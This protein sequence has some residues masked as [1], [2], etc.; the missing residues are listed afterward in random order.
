[1]SRRLDEILPWLPELRRQW[2]EIDA[3]HRVFA[4]HFGVRPI[5]WSRHNLTRLLNKTGEP[6][7]RILAVRDLIDHRLRMDSAIDQRYLVDCLSVWDHG[8]MWARDGQPCMMV[9]HPYHIND[10]ERALLD[11]LARW[12]PRLKLSIDD[13]ESYY[14]PKCTHHI[15]LEL[16]RF[17]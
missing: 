17:P 1:M 3:R 9:G 10:E 4:D 6:R 11:E 14:Y 13:R 8:E 5:K 2:A 12:S 16:V 15:R 7:E